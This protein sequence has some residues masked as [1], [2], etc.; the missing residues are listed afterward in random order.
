MNQRDIGPFQMESTIVL[1]GLLPI[2]QGIETAQ[3]F[4][5]DKVVQALENMESIDTIYGKGRMGGMEIFGINHVVVRPITLSR[6]MHG[7]VEFEF[8]K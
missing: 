1:D 7:K 4:D 2:L 8:L 5:T 3:S 6:I